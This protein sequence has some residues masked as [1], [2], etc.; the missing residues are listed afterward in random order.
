M[1]TVIVGGKMEGDRWVD[2]QDA[3][4]KSISC[5]AVVGRS[6]PLPILESSLLKMGAKQTYRGGITSPEGGGK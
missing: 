6:P 3:W 1:T 4:V 2:S 5:T